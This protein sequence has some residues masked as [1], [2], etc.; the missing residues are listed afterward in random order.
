MGVKGREG[1]LYRDE[2]CW[3]LLCFWLNL[4]KVLR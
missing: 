2:M 1:Y 4:D 3:V